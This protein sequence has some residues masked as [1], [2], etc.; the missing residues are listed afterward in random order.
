LDVGIHIVDRV[1][2]GVHILLQLLPGVDP[3]VRQVL[4]HFILVI[5]HDLDVRILVL[6]ILVG[7]EVRLIALVFSRVTVT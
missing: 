2:I 5:V 6:E 1:N 3:L 4:A 7:R